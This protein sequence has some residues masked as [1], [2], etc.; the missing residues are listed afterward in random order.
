M[1]AYREKIYSRYASVIQGTQPVFDAPGA[2]RWARPYQTYLSGW[3]PL[4]K[5]API[6]EVVCGSGSLLYFLKTL[7]FVNL[8]GVDHSAEQVE[9]ALQVVEDVT[10]DDAIAYLKRHPEAFDL[11]I[12]F[13]IVE[14]FKKDEVFEFL[15]SCHA[16]LRPGGRLVLKT[17]NAESP[18]GLCIRYGDLSHEVAFDLIV[19]PGSWS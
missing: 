7:G 16:S 14:H 4:A 10:Q 8:Q 13:D 6:L 18:W 12:G 5:N 19:C 1:D 11:I 9:I 17:P 15:E 3:L 2:E